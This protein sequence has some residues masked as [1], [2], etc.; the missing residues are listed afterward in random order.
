MPFVALSLLV[1][2]AWTALASATGVLLPLYLYPSSKFN[3]GAANWNPVVAAASSSPSLPFLT[4]V[5]PSNGPGRTGRPGDGDA[6][7]VTGVSRL[8]TLRNVKT[9]GYVRTNYSAA[10]M[11][12]LKANMSIWKSW[13]TYP[14]ANISMHGIFL[15]ESAANAAYMAEAAAFAR[16]TFGPSATVVCNFGTAA[17]EAYY[18]VCDVV[19]AFES[20]LNCALGP[21]YRSGETIR[22][23]IPARRRARAAVIV[24]HFA[25][26]AFDGS[27]A[28]E[29]LLGRYAA[30]VKR[31]GVGWAYFCSGGYDDVRSRPAT[32]GAVAE[33]LR[34]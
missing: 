24:N 31:E 34:A 17:P 26:R 19:V 1:V 2:A 6:N 7:Y 33:G 15:D 16:K 5:N 21:R 29:A 14:S 32:I 11:A 22:A 12:E 4:V 23:S 28:D 9:I 25:G 20:C 3:D 18:D 30:D 10:P 13:S 8:N 27:V